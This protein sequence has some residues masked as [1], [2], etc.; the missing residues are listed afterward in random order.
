MSGDRFTSLKVESTE[1]TGITLDKWSGTLTI[2][3]DFTVE[4]KGKE[5]G[6]YG[7]GTGSDKLIING[8][9]VKATGTDEGSITEFSALEG[10]SKLTRP[11]L[12][13]YDW[14]VKSGLLIMKNEVVIQP[15]IRI[16]G[17]GVNIDK[18]GYVDG[19][20]KKVS[21]NNENK[22]LKI[23]NAD[24]KAGDGFNAI[25]SLVPNL[26]ISL[27]GSNKVSSTDSPAIYAKKDL[28]ISGPVGTSLTAISTKDA[29]IKIDDSSLHV[30]DGCTVIAKG[31]NYGIFG[32][33]ASVL[34]VLNSIVKATGPGI[35][36]IAGFSELV[37]E[38]E[39][40]T[41]RL[42]QPANA[43][44]FREGVSVVNDIMRIR[45]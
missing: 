34:N 5:R 12:G 31:A 43:R 33:K 24:I 40:N 3:G 13:Y 8:S 27:L 2:E 21:F 6:I 32:S 11:A 20:D 4:S 14:A 19:F 30:E 26:T 25:Y 10:F 41:S 15:L 17:I 39:G 23:N 35:A 7:K 9:T 28:Y 16:A 36:S 37:L 45:V 18:A 22:N 38:Y 29:G 1:S 44:N 42:T